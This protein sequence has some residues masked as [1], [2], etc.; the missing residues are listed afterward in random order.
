MAVFVDVP[1]RAAGVPHRTCQRRPEFG[2]EAFGGLP[3][4]LD[5]LSV[6]LPESVE[7]RDDVPH[8]SFDHVDDRACAAT[9]V[10]A[11]KQEEVRKAR[12]AQAEICARHTGP[13]LRQ[14]TV[15]FAGDLHRRDEAMGLEAGREDDHVS[16]AFVAVLGP[17]A[18][19]GHLSDPIGDELDIGPGQCGI[20]SVGG[21][22]TFAADRVYR[23]HLATKIG[24]ADGLGDLVPGNGTEGG[25]E[26]GLVRQ[27]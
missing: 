3:A 16:R 27:G 26:P 10:W 12:S 14:R 1:V 5:P 25:P 24:V 4:N 22:H 18:V 20:P 9:R 17:D 6:G 19:T 13:D 11:I 15:A 7:C 8:A 2:V 21:H 23:G